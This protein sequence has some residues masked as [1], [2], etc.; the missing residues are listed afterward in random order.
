MDGFG[1]DIDL[2]M[3]AIRAIHFAATAIIAGTLMFR[4]VVAEPAFRSAR[5]AQA[6]IDAHV[7]LLAWTGLAVAVVSGTIWLALQTAAM[8][9]QALGEAVAS[10]VMMTVLNET[11]FGLGSEVRL[12]LAILLAICLAFDRPAVSRW[13]SLGLA[14]GFLAAIAWTGHAASTPGELGYLHLTAD[15]L[16]LSAAAAWTG[17]LVPL[18]LLLDASRRRQQVVAWAPLEYDAVKRFSSLGM[19]SV[20]TLIISGLINA[21]ILVGSIR[22]LVETGYGWLLLAKVSVFAV[23]VAFAAV[24]RWRLTPQLALAPESKAQHSAFRQLTRNVVIEIALGVAIY[25]IVGVL[26]IQHPAVH[27]VR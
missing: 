23:M 22:G 11:Q 3:A 21:W 2:P 12:G 7:R 4:A 16:H 10:G 27:L 20:A 15:V 25:A 5:E 13:L 17:G 6:T 9:G 8:S 1:V 14:V 24:N 26:G 19:V 18:A